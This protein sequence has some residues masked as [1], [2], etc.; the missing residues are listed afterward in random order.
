LWAVHHVWQFAGL[1]FMTSLITMLLHVLLNWMTTSWFNLPSMSLS[2]SV[3]A[4]LLWMGITTSGALHQIST[5]TQLLVDW[6]PHLSKYWEGYFH[7]LGTLLFMPYTLAG[8]GLALV[9]LL[10]SRI[11]FILS[12]LG[13][14]LA[15][16]LMELFHIHTLSG[17]SYEGFN[18]I[19]VF[20]AM[21]GIFFLPSFSSALIAVVAAVIAML[22]SMYLPFLN[23]AM[24]PPVFAL[25]FNLTVILL[26]FI[27]KLRIKNTHPYLIDWGINLPEFNLEYYLNKLM[28]FSKIGIPQ[29]CLPF[30]GEWIVS[31]GWHG[32]YTHKHDW[33][34][35]WDFEIQDTFGKRWADREDLASE[36]YCFG[37]PVVASAPG[38]VAVV[39]NTVADNA[40]DEINTQDN[41]GNYV[42]ISHGYGLYTLYAHLKQGSVLVKPGEVVSQGM[43]VG[44]VGNSGRSPRPHLHFQ[45]QIGAYPGSKTLKCQI[46]NYKQQQSPESFGFVSSGEPKEG[47]F[48]SPLIPSPNLQ[49][50]LGLQYFQKLQLQVQKGKKTTLETWNV[51]LDWMGAFRIVSDAGNALEFSIYN[52]IYS[53]MLLKGRKLNALFGFAYLLS[54]LPYAENQNLSWE[55]KPSISVVFNPLLKNLILFTT[56]TYNPLRAI[57]KTSMT[58]NQYNIA[59]SS[60]TTIRFLGI[61]VKSWEGE[62]VFQKKVG[63]QSILLKN[64]KAVLLKAT[65]EAA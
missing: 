54:R 15:N 23:A 22:L 58:E 32:E 65:S 62:I 41:W 8:I 48:V 36:F 47:Q 42:T 56:P 39:V 2:F 59:L 16:F 38:T 3:M 64:S 9:L 18:I 63:L 12:I 21:G 14:T 13:W 45:V 10:S 30:H 6:S 28:R 51:Q 35:A 61:K 49:E 52:G 55:D 20:I 37:K 44:L 40:V 26:V 24:H 60:V 25:P 57:T 27:Q 33:A 31:Q 46:V 11:A 34:Y 7:S 53:S 17:M 4:I 1:L 50:I 43:K 19:L 29:F 5:H